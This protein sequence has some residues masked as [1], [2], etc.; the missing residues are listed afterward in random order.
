MVG[1]REIDSLHRKGELL[2]FVLGRYNTPREVDRIFC[3]I[4][5]KSS[6]SIPEKIGHARYAMFLKDYYYDITEPLRNTKADIY[7]Y[8][9]DEIILS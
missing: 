3:F 1:L 2:N 4:D 7:Q 8:I 6:N 5:L 9:G